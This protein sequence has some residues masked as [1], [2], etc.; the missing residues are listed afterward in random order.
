MDVN[1][2]IIVPF[3]AVEPTL[4][5]SETHSDLRRAIAFCAAAVSCSVEELI[6]SQSQPEKMLRLYL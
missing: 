5:L 3:S 4:C 6:A 2:I 1:I